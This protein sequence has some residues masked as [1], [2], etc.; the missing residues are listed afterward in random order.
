MAN[1][2][3]KYTTRVCKSF[4]YRSTTDDTR[5]YCCLPTGHRGW[6]AVTDD[7]RGPQWKRGSGYV[8]VQEPK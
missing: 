7:R 4:I 6:H 1:Y 5:I 8:V 2:M 3:K